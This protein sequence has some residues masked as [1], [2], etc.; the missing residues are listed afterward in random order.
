MPGNK[1]KKTLIVLMSVLALS[2]CGTV[3]AVA[4]TLTGTGYVITNETVSVVVPSTL[5]FTLD[6]LEINGLGTVF[7]DKYP[8]V[9]LG[10]TDVILT[11]TDIKVIFGND[12]DFVMSDVPVGADEIGGLKKAYLLL[13]FGNPDIEPIVLTDDSAAI[14]PEMILKAEFKENAEYSLSVAGSIS[15]YPDSDWKTGDVSISLTYRLDS[16]VIEEAAQTEEAIQIAE[17]VE[18]PEA[19][20]APAPADA[21]EQPG[22]P[23][24]TEEQTGPSEES[25]PTDTP[26][27]EEDNQPL[28]EQEDIE[29]VSGE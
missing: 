8:L 29:N 26:N 14:P 1:L 2:V 17:P 7:S 5:D 23:A 16:A 11:F 18:I 27:T 4:Y 3:S 21:P 6:P 15:S 28:S 22:E 24:Q 25:A 10:A 13:D 12:T 9:N 19:I 20:E